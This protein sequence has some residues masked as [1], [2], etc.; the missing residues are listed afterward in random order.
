MKQSFS[1]HH[2]NMIKRQILPHGLFEEHILEAFEKTPRS[3]FL[4]EDKKM[5]AFVEDP[6]FLEG[7]RVVYKP[8]SYAFLMQFLPV[9]KDKNIMIVG[10][11]VGYGAA[12]LSYQGST[13][14]LLESDDRYNQVAQEG[15]KRA[16]VE[17]V[18]LCQGNMRDGL[19]RQSPFW[20]IV[21]EGS[22]SSI[23]VAYF[24]Q[25]EEGSPGVFAV[26]HIDGQG[27]CFCRFFQND[28]GTIERVPLFKEIQ[29][30]MPEFKEKEKFV[31]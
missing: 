9:A 15:C 19:K 22:V 21:M 10:G 4:P 18:V 14:F 6:I 30:E 16:G 23:P 7:R 20:Y 3:L 13:V 17:N 12:L 27:P 8:L 25:L 28:K 2:Q 5:E 26:T 11:S 29:F 24:E 31:F 1:I